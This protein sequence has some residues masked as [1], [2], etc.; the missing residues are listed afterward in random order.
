MKL[1]IQDRVAL[2]YSAQGSQRA[3]ARFLGL[4][5]QQVGRLLRIGQKGGYPLNS[6][7]LKNEFLPLIV[8]QAFEEHKQIVRA[9]ARADDLPF[10]AAVP[11]YSARM[12]FSDGVRGDRVEANHLHWLSDSLRNAW[13]LDIKKSRKYAQISIGSIVSLVD[14]NR[15]AQN[16][17]KAQYRDDPK[18]QQ[19]KSFLLNALVR[20]AD[21]TGSDA[22]LDIVPKHLLTADGIKEMSS[23]D[24]AQISRK[25]QALKLETVTGRVQTPYVPMTQGFSNDDVLMSI[26]ARLS[27]KHAPAVGEPGTVLADRILLQVDT[28]NEKDKKFRDANKRQAKPRKARRNAGSGKPRKSGKR[29]R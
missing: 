9:R 27:E 6:R 20:A 12:L 19:A 24:I 17:Q 4:S 3:T 25:L 21:Q 23:S 22:P 28:R 5:H 1:S 26:D 16:A 10:S 15:L 13:I 29:K 11:I 14:Y 2:I 7:V 18:L 8:N